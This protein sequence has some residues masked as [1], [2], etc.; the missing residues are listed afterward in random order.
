M[1][2]QGDLADIWSTVTSTEAEIAASLQMHV[3]QTVAGNAA[4]THLNASKYIPWMKWN[5]VNVDNKD[6]WK[7]HK[8]LEAKAYSTFK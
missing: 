5:H 1:I 6:Y 2:I 7:I 3:E 4:S 8:S